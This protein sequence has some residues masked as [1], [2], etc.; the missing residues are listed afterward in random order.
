MM[1]EQ[2]SITVSG[3]ELFA[4][5]FKKRNVNIAKQILDMEMQTKFDGSRSLNGLGHF[6]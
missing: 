6:S 1:V 4:H 2:T 3:L 5:Y